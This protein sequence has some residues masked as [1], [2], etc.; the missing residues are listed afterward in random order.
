[1]HFKSKSKL[2]DYTSCVN[3]FFKNLIKL[4]DYIS[5]WMLVNAFN[6]NSEEIS[7]T[8]FPQ[9]L[10]TAALHKVHAS[11]NTFSYQSGFWVIGLNK[12]RTAALYKVY[13]SC[14]TLSNQSGSC[15]IGVRVQPLPSPQN[16]AQYFLLLLL[17]VQ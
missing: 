5:W 17:G 2:Q 9:K 14:N 8:S 12:L 4:R 16:N 1:M 11:W 6:E 15:G 7:T 10:R 3:F 13:G